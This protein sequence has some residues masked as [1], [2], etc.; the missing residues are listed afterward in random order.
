[1]RRT[2]VDAGPVIRH[3]GAVADVELLPGNG[4]PPLVAGESAHGDTVAAIANAV[5][6]VI[7]V[8]VRSL[9]RTRGCQEV[10]LYGVPTST[11]YVRPPPAPM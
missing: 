7:V 10:S 2:I 8:R 5:C 6:H 1:V 4:N 11:C 9:P 3:Q